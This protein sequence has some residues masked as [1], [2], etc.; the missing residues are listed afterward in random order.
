MALTKISTDGFKDD[1]VTTDKLANAINT[2]RT[3]NT[4]KVSTTINNNADNRVITGSGTANTLEGESG[5]TYNGTRLNVG[6]G[7][8][9]VTGAEGGDAQLR[10]T[11]DEGD[12]GADYWRLE[13]KASD[14]NFNLATYS[15]GAWVDKVTVNTSGVTIKGATNA[16]ARLLLQNTTSVRTNYIGLSGD[17]DRI[18]IAADDADQG[19]NS[20]IDFKVDGSERMRIDS[21]GN[22]GI[23]TTSPSSFY[24]EADNLVVS[25]SGHTGITINSGSATST[26]RGNIVFSEGT[27]GDNDKW[28]GVIE[29]KHGDD[30]MRFIT[31]ASERM[32]ITDAGYLK[33]TANGASTGSNNCH[34]LSNANA[35]TYGAQIFQTASNGYGLSIDVNSNLSSR[36][37][38]NLYATTD[39]EQKA[40]IMMN[41]N[42]YSRSNSYG[43][44]S[45]QKLKENIVDATSQW[46]DIKNIKIRNFNFKSDSS[47]TKLLGVVA[48]EIETVSPALV[49]EVPDKEK[50]D[51]EI[52]ETGTKTKTVKYSVLY[53]KA[54]KALQEAMAKIET[55]ETKVAALEAG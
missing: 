19:S 20:T 43:A 53:M 12:D 24:S 4:A 51:G 38:F 29:Y 7:D 40:A 52:V 14:N 28:R 41:G 48:Q 15:T 45:D 2:E 33:A 22:V 5:L 34:V 47:N 17:D 36:E 31:N 37:G 6:T 8:L 55:L 16:A 23:G 13:S 32:R 44:F 18:V 1:A 54:I 35:A 10:L 30:F 11:A 27:A 9:A 26:S 25:S 39:S 49:D 46:N 3:A 21:S 50:K 42:F